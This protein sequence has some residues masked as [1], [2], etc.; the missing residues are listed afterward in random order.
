M[1]LASRFGRTNQIRRDRPLTHDELRQHVPSVFGEDKHE[2]RSDRY[3]YIPTITLLENL[4]R[5][6]FQPFFACQSRVRDPDRREHT[7]HML[8]L[9]R[10]GQINDQQVPEII[11]LN[12]HDGASSFQLL[13]GI[14]RSVCSNSL[15]C[16]QSFGEIRVPHRGNVV[17]R[18]IE[19]AYEVLGIF[20]QVE[21]KREA[22]QS[23]LLPPPAQQAL[24]KAALMYRFGEEHQP[25]TEAQAL[26][27]RRWQ[28]E[29]NDLWTVF[30]R[31]QENLSKG[32]L[33]GRSA[34]GKRSRTRAVN[35]IDGDLKLNRAL[36]VMAE[37]L[38]QA[39]S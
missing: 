34:Q 38:Q 13:P 22:M 1:R 2:S 35:G 12:S 9:R 16:G 6:G 4:Q 7:K 31:L 39:L 36:W 14:F 10:A 21:E 18:V 8:R 20:D 19:G 17:E 32:G 28:D 26:T 23:L 3:C 33:V 25:V 11:I 15:V 24:A 27:P 29:K 37:E 5:E 30:N